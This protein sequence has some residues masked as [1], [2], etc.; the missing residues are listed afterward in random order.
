MSLVWGVRGY[1]YNNYVSTDET[2]K[3]IKEFLK[4]NNLVGTDDL[5]INIASIPMEEK[6]R[7]NMLKLSYIS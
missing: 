5:I 7:A 6:G 2:I 3:E 1:Y 4:K